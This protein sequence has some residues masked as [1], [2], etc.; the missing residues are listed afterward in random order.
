M[1]DLMVVYTF[2]VDEPIGRRLNNTAVAARDTTVG[3]TVDES[4]MVG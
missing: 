2:Y 3:T 4:A 1:G